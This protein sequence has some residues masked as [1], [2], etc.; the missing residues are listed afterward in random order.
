MSYESKSSY[1]VEEILDKQRKSNKVYYKIKW[2][3]YPLDQ[4]TWE[5][6][7]HLSKNCDRLI[8]EFERKVKKNR[9]QMRKKKQKE[10]K[11][12][13]I[14]DEFVRM[15]YRKNLRRVD[16]AMEYVQR[17]RAKNSV[18]DEDAGFINDDSLSDRGEK[19]GLNYFE[20]SLAQGKGQSISN[21]VKHM[22]FGSKPL[23]KKRF[24]SQWKSGSSNNQYL[25]PRVSHSFDRSERFKKSNLPHLQDLK[26]QMSRHKPKSNPHPDPIFR[27]HMNFPSMS[28]NNLPVIEFSD[29]Q[30]DR[31]F[32]RMGSDQ[33]IQKSPREMSKNYGSSSDEE[34]QKCIKKENIESGFLN[35]RKREHL[36]RRSSRK[37][38]G[39]ILN[40]SLGRRA[41]AHSKINFERDFQTS[42]FHNKN[43]TNAFQ[44]ILQSKNVQIQNKIPVFARS[45]P[46]PSMS[47]SDQSSRIK[48]SS[49]KVQFSFDK[50]QHFKQEN[51]ETLHFDKRQ[52]EILIVKPKPKAI[53]F[54]Q[55]MQ[56]K[57]AKKVGA[58]IEGVIEQSPVEQIASQLSQNFSDEQLE[59]FGFERI[60]ELVFKRKL[61]Q[62]NLKAIENEK[63]LKK[64][65]KG[66]QSKM[67][68]MLDESKSRSKSKSKGKGRVEGSKWNHKM[69]VTPN[70]RQTE[71][72]QGNE[73]TSEYERIENFFSN[74]SKPDKKIV[75]NTTQSKNKNY[76]QKDDFTL[77]FKQNTPN[78]KLSKPKK[79]EKKNEIFTPFKM[80]SEYIQ[81]ETIRMAQDEIIKFN[82]ERGTARPEEIL[83][84]N[85]HI[86]PK[87][88]QNDS[89]PKDPLENMEVVAVS[90][91]NSKKEKKMIDCF[92]SVKRKKSKVIEMDSNDQKSSKVVCILKD[93]ETKKPGD[94]LESLDNVKN[95]K[96]LK[97]F[98]NKENVFCVH[99]SQSEED[100]ATKQD[101]EN[102]DPSNSNIENKPKSK[103]VILMGPD[104]EN[105]CLKLRTTQP[106]NEDNESEEVQ[107]KSLANLQKRNFS[108]FNDT[109]DLP[110]IPNQPMVIQHSS[111]TSDVKTLNFASLNANL[112][113]KDMQPDTNCNNLISKRK[114]T[115][116]VKEASTDCLDLESVT[117]G[118]YLL[119]Y[120]DDIEI[121]GNIILEGKLYFRIRRTG[122]L[123]ESKGQERKVEQM[124]LPSS[125]L[126]KI[127]PDLLCLYLEKHMKFV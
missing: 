53:I 115:K 118:Q 102:K 78:Q 51:P 1:E 66:F 19:A 72:V 71:E 42:Y 32:G 47:S 113:Q 76:P 75:D 8:K 56:S 79:P 50:K 55:M 14:P 41:P 2:M 16:K 54:E 18:K 60:E 9:R 11:T 95:L 61:K 48:S 59:E 21:L 3:G 43:S 46:M 84:F 121:L 86:L 98:L 13:T 119:R 74:I 90:S 94:N 93:K 28:E 122:K 124:F 22:R 7:H 92:T 25:N 88:L 109:S 126:R 58:R 36:V 44:S 34:D 17:Q 65:M 110:P 4:C 40:P 35:H 24:S 15:N 105:H 111:G 81:E 67:V 108:S 12:R 117:C 91:S 99:R 123:E 57:R 125:V 10:Q 38:K 96:W 33:N 5:P 101:G 97:N 114:N 100:S 39:V 70:K 106:Q 80:N 69:S 87:L 73:R 112:N 62:E 31:S 27:N 52:N 37:K 49:K 83:Y 89:P 64:K 23:D 107:I 20:D 26:K 68:E 116:K 45:Q 103:S 85:E 77:T 120:T 63:K 104:L 30:R 29:K 82:V 127:R 6:A